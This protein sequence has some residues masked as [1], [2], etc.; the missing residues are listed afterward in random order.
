MSNLDAIL[1]NHQMTGC[2]SGK[3]EKQEDAYYA[4]FANDRPKLLQGTHLMHALAECIKLLKNSC[5]ISMH[6]PFKIKTTVIYQCL[7]HKIFTVA[8]LH[9]L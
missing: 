3:T 5:R 9:N 1:R 2:F 8:L 4:F 6:N 7:Y